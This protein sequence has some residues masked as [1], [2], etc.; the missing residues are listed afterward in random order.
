M[1]TQAKRRRPCGTAPLG[2]E[3][4]SVG[5]RHQLIEGQG[6][7]RHLGRRQHEFRD[8]VL[9]HDGL[10]LGHAL[11]VAEVPAHHFGG[12]LIALRQLFDVGLQLGR[13][14]LQ[15]VGT[16]QLG[17]DQAQ[18]HP[19]LG[20][21][22]EDV[23]RD[24]GLV[25]ILDAALL[26]VLTGCGHHALG[27]ALHQCVGHV[28]LGDGHQGVHHGGLVAGQHAE[29]H[30]ALEVLLDVSAQGL[31]GR[32]LDAQR[33]RKGL[34]HFGQV[35]RLDLLDRD[36]EVGFL[37]GHVLAVVVLGE[38]QREGLALASLHAA[39]GGVELLQHLAFADQELEAFGLAALE[40][41]AVD[42]AFE[43]DGD[44]VTGLGHVGSGALG[45]AAALLAQD[46]DGLV[47]GFFGH[48]AGDALDLG[49]GQVADLDLGVD[50]EGGI[51]SHLALGRLVLLLDA[52]QAGHAQLGFVGGVVES[53]AQLV[54]DDFVLHRIAVA[55]GDD[56]HRHLAGAEAVGLD[57]AGQL[58]QTGFDF[59]V[60]VS[61][62][63]VQGDAAFQLFEGFD[64]DGH[65]GLGN[66]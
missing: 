30:L 53:R 41:L 16:H 62:R 7:V 42:L 1:A 58:L 36:E 12:L 32:V 64:G 2:G 19:T 40:G 26:Q 23:G 66:S 63:H 38:L 65:D 18:A 51:E 35:L 56:V 34:V 47:D 9:D 11:T 54:V 31:D 6:L 10:N 13:F 52:R 59:A 8:V 21:R 37:A 55:L 4:H 49:G 60:D 5:S 43:V 15:I 45:E 33:L 20:L 14:G 48:V 29:L 39:H 50:L 24:L 22:L 3:G 17:H 46:L 57:G 44:A 28:E 61:G 25:G 27:L